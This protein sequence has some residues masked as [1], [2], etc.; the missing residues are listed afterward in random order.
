MSTMTQWGEAPGVVPGL[1]DAL[2]SLM[3][4]AAGDGDL[5]RLG[6]EEVTDA[7]SVVGQVRQM[8]EVAEVALVREGMERGLPAES[9]WSAHDWVS[10]AEGE[11]APVPPVRHVA[12]T[13]RVARGGAARSASGLQPLDPH[14]TDS[15]TETPDA[16][17][18]LQ[19][20]FAEGDLPLGKADQLVR[21]HASVARVADPDLLERDLGVLLE[22]AR[23]D[24]VATGPQS[25]VT[26]RRHGLSE[27]ELAAAITMAARLLKPVKGQD[28]EDRR[29]KA[30]R[31]LTKGAGPCGL[32]KY[33]LVLDA[34]GA[35]VVES[36][37]AAHS[38][39]V[40]GANGEKDPR[41][42]TRRRADAL[43]EVL[44]RGVS[45][46]GAAPKSEKAQVV[47]TI[48]LEAL[49]E[50]LQGA[51]VTAT[52]EV[53]PPGVVRRMACDGGIIPAVLGGKG[54]V[55][56]LGRT[57]RWFTPGQKRA[58]W[59]RDGGCTFPGCTMPPQWTDAHHV[60]WWSRGGASDITNG[61]LLCERHH[62]HVHQE[63]LTATITATGVTWHV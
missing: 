34:E 42:A 43:L 51:G 15:D 47:V 50:G 53:L 55:L 20:A 49:L 22:G 63:D 16:L 52:G 46:P 24:V 2:R 8:V 45:S 1:R 19:G 59:L 3:V 32:T 41:P 29:A 37:L 6:D 28:D 23:D 9:S 27:R 44:R 31:S 21:F 56:E 39:P 35:A 61:A 25:R 13:V 57:V 62:T 14:D 12:S 7:L 38:G 54:E 4:G 17:T 58:L 26:Q 18:R 60:D 10:T 33:T 40:T 30:G 11:R 48:G 5:W 36:V